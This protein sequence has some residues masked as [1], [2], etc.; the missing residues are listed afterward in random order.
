MQ[1]LSYAAPPHREP[2]RPPG[3]RVVGTTSLLIGGAGALI[4]LLVLMLIGSGPSA[5]PDSPRPFDLHWMVVNVFF[6]SF[7]VAIWLL[8]L[9]VRTFRADRGQLPRL[10]RPYYW[11]IVGQVVVAGGYAAVVLASDVDVQQPLPM[12]ICVRDAAFWFAVLAAYPLLM[13]PLIRSSAFKD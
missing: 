10:R 7:A 3:V 5:P 9:G 4:H 11:C 8:T 12:A 1:T 13:I 2:R 6:A